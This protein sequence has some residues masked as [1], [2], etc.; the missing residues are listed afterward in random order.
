MRGYT[1]YDIE[2]RTGR[3]IKQMVLRALQF[4]NGDPKG[5]VYL[6]CPREVPE[7]QIAPI[8]AD[9]SRWQPLGPST[10]TADQVHDIAEGLEHSTRP[11]TGDGS[12]LFSVPSTVH[13][14]ALRYGTPFLQIIFNN[15]GWKSPK[16]SLLFEHPDGYASKS[17]DLPVSF[18]D[19]ADYAGI[20]IAAGDAFGRR[21]ERV[22][23]LDDALSEGVRIVQEE[24]RCAVIDVQLPQL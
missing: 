6:V 24:Q 17:S 13:W 11:L 8:E 15:G 5:P 9:Q 22:S 18:D 10:L 3:N 7:E 16:L 2:L 20:A 19:P 12:Y 1:R 4:A 14:M 21:V 23:E